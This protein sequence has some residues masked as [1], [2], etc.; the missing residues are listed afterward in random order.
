MRSRTLILS[1]ICWLSF[2]LASAQQAEEMT[3]SEK[4]FDFGTVKE[5]DGP[6]IH[7]FSFINK[8]IEPLKIASV[9]ASCG[10][11]TPDWT[12]EEVKPGQ[13]GYIQAQY[14]PK[15]RPGSF[16][17][18]LTVSLE[19]SETPVRLYIRGNVVPTP[20]SLE[21][22]LTAEMGGI[23]VK[24]RSFNMG[25]VLTSE[26]PTTKEFDVFNSSDKAITF[27]DKVVGPNYIKLAF[28]PQT[29]KP[30]EK[31]VVKVIYD[32]QL[33]K[34]L[35]F[36]SDNVKFYTDEAL[37]PEKSI[38][39]Y[40]TVLEYFPPMSPEELAKAP[41]LKIESPVYDFGKLK[42]DQEASTTF[43]LRNTGQSELKIRQAKPNCSCTGASVKKETLKPGEST[44]IKVT[45]DSKGRR[46]NQ[47]KSVTIFSNDPTASA[48]RVTIKAYINSEG[49]SK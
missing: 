36:S 44:E 18:S 9:K 3:F 49:D 16:N 21:D 47:Q 5:E 10:C 2:Y 15:N 45:F 11:T 38:S 19:G 46:G 24:Y 34:E 7:Q 27:N 28:E 42:A 39:V 31:G 6:I 14:N 1:V 8:G 33:N 25:K 40:A 4:T 12:K 41:K 29:L 35:G 30:K 22:E 26:E 13:T 37:E 43:T 17:K 32:A 23:S 48:Q 20:K